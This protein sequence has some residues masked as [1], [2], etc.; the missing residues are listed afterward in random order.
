MGYRGGSA[1]IIDYGQGD[2]VSPGRRES[3][4]RV[5]IRSG[6]S[7]RERPAPAGDSS[8]GVAAAV[9]ELA[10]DACLAARWSEGRARHLISWRCYGYRSRSAVGAPVVVGD[11]QR[12][13]IVLRRSKTVRRVALG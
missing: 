13:G 1:V 6:C 5:G 9:G 8:V 3:V 11:G 10:G 4:E 7:A 12:H 2:A